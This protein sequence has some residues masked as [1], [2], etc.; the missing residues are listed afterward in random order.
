MK[1]DV[2]GDSVF[3]STGG[4]E[5]DASLPCIVFLHGA[6]MD[7]T[8]WTLNSRYFARNG[9]SVLAPDLPG[10]GLSG[11]GALSTIEGLADWLFQLL[12]AMGLDQVRVA[13]HSMGAL[14]A[15]E[16]ASNQP[17]RI[18]HLALLGAAFPMAVGE[19]LLNAAQ[20]NEHSSI[21]MVSLFGTAYG[22]Q[23]GHN[24]MAGVS[25]LNNCVRVLE[26]ANPGVMYNSLFAC[27]SYVNGEVAAKGVTSVTTM[28]VGTRDQM[29]PPRAA[30]N[31]AQLLGQV[32]IIELEGCGHMHPAEA[33]E[34]C[35]QALVKAF[36]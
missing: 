6:A 9:Y 22:S 28:I 35:H 24:A 36:T 7:H 16:A 21:D 17:Q 13:G 32:P 31:L 3:V 20:A 34:A 11:G 33:P 23:L 5:F 15:L 25:V 14:V 26:R 19:P 4:V 12:D 1:I 29:A 18:S 2:N 30:K 10:H 8:F 27:N